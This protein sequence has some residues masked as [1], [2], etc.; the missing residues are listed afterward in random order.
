MPNNVVR[1]VFDVNCYYAAAAAPMGY[2]QQWLQIARTGRR[3]KLY[4]SPEIL[5]ELQTKLEHKLG[6]PAFE[7]VDFRRYIEAIATVVH[8]TSRLSVVRDPDDN[9]ILEC[10]VEAKAAAI[11][12]FDKDLLDLKEYKGTKIIHPR[13]LKYWFPTASA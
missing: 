1:L 8:P 12:T 3:F 10:A 2:M 6:Q 9:K 7:S 13:M 4:T 11:I 5:A